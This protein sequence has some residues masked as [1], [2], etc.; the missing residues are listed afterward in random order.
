VSATRER[1]IAGRYEVTT[2]IGRG[3]MGEVWAAYDT[4][5][6]RR[7]ALKLLRPELVPP[8]THGRSVVARFRR[9]A[10]LTARLEHPGVPAVFDVGAEGDVLF[11]AMQLVDGQDLGDVLAGRGALPVEWAVAIGAQL[12]AVLAAAHAVSLVH[13]DLKPRNVM[14]ARGGVVRV[15]DF[16]VAALL[17]PEITR[18]TAAG[19]TVGSPAYMAPEQLTSA[20]ASPRTDLYALGCVLHELLAGEEVF[21]APTAAA[22]MYA[23]LERDPEPLR[24]LRPEV[25]ETVEHLVLDLLAKDPEARPDGADEV[26]RRLQPLLP[27]GTGEAPAGGDPLDPTRPYRC[28]LAPSARAPRSP[29]AVAPPALPEPLAQV[30]RR[31]VDLADDGR[32][33]QAAELLARRLRDARE[34]RPELLAVRLQ[35]AHTLLL[36]GDYRRALPEFEDLVAELTELRG[37][38]DRDVIGCRIQAATCRA[39]LGELS[40]AIDE[41]SDVLELH[42]GLS[43]GTDP[44]VLD[45]RRRIALLLASAGDLRAAEQALRELRRDKKRLVGD[46]HVEVQ[47]LSDLLDRVDAARRRAAPGRAERIRQ[48][49][50][51][52]GNRAGD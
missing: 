36:G 21:S 34:S 30:R 11:L 20:S 13:R 5:L 3:G 39:E 49:D 16:G 7:V 4:K 45:L 50:T 33:T 37:T 1:V 31:A 26:Y 48:V 32:F 22:Q 51:N 9:E 29:A 27:V 2:P 10:R 28:P 6:D 46:G 12:A 23:H 42:R 14:L 8:G 25:P 52:D 17:D 38:T 41:L 35:Y 40:A 24:A 43:G 19:E 47:E 15:L 44:E 18:V